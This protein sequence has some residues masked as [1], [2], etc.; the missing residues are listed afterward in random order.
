MKVTP[1]LER[2]RENPRDTRHVVRIELGFYDD[3]AAEMFALVVF[4]SDGLLRVGESADPTPPATSRFFSIATG[5]PNGAVLSPGGIR[6]G[7]LAR[8]RQ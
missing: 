1:L 3:V 4:V 8:Q 2:F 5:T 7:D 6:Q